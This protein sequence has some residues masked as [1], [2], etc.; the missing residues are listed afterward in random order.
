[1]RERALHEIRQ[2]R[3]LRHFA[4]RLQDHI[5]ERVEIG[6]S[7]HK[8]DRSDI[9]LIA[10]HRLSASDRHARKRT[11]DLLT[12]HQ[13]G[14]ETHERQR[15]EG[16]RRRSPIGHW[17]LRSPRRVGFQFDGLSEIV[18]RL[19]IQLI[20]RSAVF[21][22]SSYSQTQL[23]LSAE[24]LGVIHDAPPKSVLVWTWVSKSL[25][26]CP[27]GRDAVPVRRGSLVHPR[28]SPSLLWGRE[29][30]QVT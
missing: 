27:P 4:E 29:H 25:L 9:R 16:D 28:I 21:H 22:Q 5:P 14:F 13:A 23:R 3:N 11:L 12:R 18:S 15:Y 24:T 30:S 2:Y 20:R 17:V 6:T 26:K 1:M 10:R 8:S 7:P 19:R